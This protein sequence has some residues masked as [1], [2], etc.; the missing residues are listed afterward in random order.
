MHDT[1]K[2]SLLPVEEMLKFKNHYNILNTIATTRAKTIKM[3][4][5]SLTMKLGAWA[6]S[7]K[8]NNHVYLN[9]NN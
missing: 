3:T 4:I 2:L 5:N 9:T 7:R 8:G 1:E 6:I